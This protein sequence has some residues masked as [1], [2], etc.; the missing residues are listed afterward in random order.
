L[1]HLLLVHVGGYRRKR[2]D[3]FGVDACGV[4]GETCRNPDDCGG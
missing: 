2:L 4:H 1:L 3:G